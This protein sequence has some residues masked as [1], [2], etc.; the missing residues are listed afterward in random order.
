MVYVGYFH[1]M[2]YVGYLNRVLG[3]FTYGNTPFLIIFL[4][5]LSFTKVKWLVVCQSK[6]GAP[7]LNY[8]LHA[9]RSLYKPSSSL[10]GHGGVIS[11]LSTKLA[12]TLIKTGDKMGGMHSQFLRMGTKVTMRKLLQGFLIISSNY[13]TSH[14]QITGQI[15]TVILHWM[16][17]SIWIIRHFIALTQIP[18]THIQTSII[19]D[20]YS[21][22]S[23]FISTEVI[24][25]LKAAHL[26]RFMCSFGL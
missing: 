2:V 3:T 1:C 24:Q 23:Q 7:I 26:I 10:S 14:A 11:L 8:S 22:D 4:V 21:F 5:W 20:L 15:N 18:W 13:H 16:S 25:K 19:V 6:W 12:L 9:A 17:L